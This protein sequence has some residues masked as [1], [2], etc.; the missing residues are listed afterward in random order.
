MYAVI[1][2]GGK[3]YKVTQ[4]DVLQIELISA[5][6]GENVTF[7]RVLLIADAGDVQLGTPILDGKTV[8]ANVIR[9]GRGKK[10][11]VVK[12]R[13]RKQYRKQLGHR[14]SFT[15]IQITAIDGK[16]GEV[17]KAPAPAAKKKA[18]A[19]KKKTAT[20]K[21]PAAKKKAAASKKKTGTKKKAT[22][23]KKTAAKKKTSTKK[24]G[25]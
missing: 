25:K 17:K 24:S 22:A 2:A 10:V 16:A 21:A 11:D 12:F 5:A 4:G 23:K 18:A 14:Q 7:D 8:T 15:E 13:R 9:H 19:S 1:E 3:Q 6:E 20:K